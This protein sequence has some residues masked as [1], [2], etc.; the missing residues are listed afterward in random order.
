MEYREDRSG[1]PIIGTPKEASFWANTDLR[2]EI[3][4]YKLDVLQRHQN[5]LTGI[6]LETNLQRAQEELDAAR[7]KEL[8][9]QSRTEK[10]IKIQSEIVRLRELETELLSKESARHQIVQSS[11][12]DVQIRSTVG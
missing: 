7:L 12:S 2:I 9:E 5:S 8:L 3:I 6:E 10:Q 4:Q 11:I 1:N